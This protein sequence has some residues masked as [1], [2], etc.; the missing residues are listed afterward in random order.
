MEPF[1][2]EKKKGRIIGRG[3][4]EKVLSGVRDGMYKVTVRKLHNSRSNRQNRWLWG[5]IYPRLL[6]GF[7]DAG[8]DDFTSEEEVHEYCKIMFAGK[9]IVNRETGEVVTI[10]CRTSE[11]DVV[12]FSL[13]CMQ[14][15]MFANDYLN[16]T[17]P[18]PSDA[19]ITESNL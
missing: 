13:Y 6:Q 14:L 2:I 9:D 12:E 17:I 3:L 11:M 4:L 19:L 18:E 1:V 7:L 16:I 8:W 10:P 15:R 5:Q